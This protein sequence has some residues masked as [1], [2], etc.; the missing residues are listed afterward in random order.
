MDTF[1]F[2]IVARD[3]GGYRQ[4]GDIAGESRFDP[5]VVAGSDGGSRYGMH[6][7]PVIPGGTVGADALAMPRV[8]GRSDPVDGFGEPL[9]VFEDP[10][11]G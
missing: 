6:V 4:I 7:D 11:F 1:V 10:L 8:L 2:R 5:E 3:D 9:F